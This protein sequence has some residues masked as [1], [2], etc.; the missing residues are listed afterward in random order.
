MT[1]QWFAGGGHAA[2]HLFIGARYLTRPEPDPAAARN[3][4]Q[5]AQ[6]GGEDVSLVMTL[7]EDPLLRGPSQRR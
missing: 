6:R 2:N 5:S 4:W 1:K 3:A 7:L